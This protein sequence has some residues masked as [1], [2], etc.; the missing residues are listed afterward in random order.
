MLEHKLSSMMTG[1]QTVAGG[2][3]SLVAILNSVD[4]GTEKRLLATLEQTD[5]ALAEEIKNRMFVFE[6]ITKLT[7]Q[8][9]Q[10]V[11]R[12]VDNRDLAIALKTAGK[13]VT[14]AVF[15]NTSKPRSGYDQG[16]HGVY[17]ARAR[18]R[19]GRGRSRRL[20]IPSASW[21]MRAK[22]LSP[23]VRRMR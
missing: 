12:E 16:R 8:A 21:T 4:R 15:D 20:S 5:T 13:E 14:K 7:D 11:L 18:T 9:I 3:D 23:A 17:G 2:L 1:S 10:R 6:D 22:S 19:R